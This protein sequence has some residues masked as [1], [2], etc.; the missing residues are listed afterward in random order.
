MIQTATY[1][2]YCTVP[3]SSVHLFCAG[4]ALALCAIALLSGACAIIAMASCASLCQ[5]YCTDESSGFT[6]AVRVSVQ[7]LFDD[8][9]DTCLAASD[10]LAAISACL[11]C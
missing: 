3:F 4:T 10:P 6:K 8:S 7:R 1:D 11:L 5:T 9:T 2:I